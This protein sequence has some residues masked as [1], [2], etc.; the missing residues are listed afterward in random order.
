MNETRRALEALLATLT[1]SVHP[2][3][4]GLAGMAPEGAEVVIT[5]VGL[6][7][8]GRSRRDGALLDLELTVTV[9]A[10]GPD[11]LDH[12]ERL[13]ITAE[14]HGMTV[15]TPPSPSALGLTLSVPVAVALAEPTAPRVETV[16]V[17][18]RPLNALGEPPDTPS[19]AP[20][21]PADTPVG[22]ATNPTETPTPP[23]GS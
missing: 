10:T 18:V 9:A 5:P 23:E 12:L 7:R 16:V 15:G 8:V 13:L 14:T 3:P 22:A 21:T 2:A 6:R 1:E 11:A 4:T 17:D 20:H 19:G